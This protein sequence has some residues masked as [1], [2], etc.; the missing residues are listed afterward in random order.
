MRQAFTMIE[1]IFVIVII[2]ILA[3]IAIPKITKS[4]VDAESSFCALEIRQLTGEIYNRFTISGHTIFSEI[5]IYDITNIRLLQNSSDGRTGIVA[6]TNIVTGVEYQCDGSII[7]K[8]IYSYES[9]TNEYKMLL[10]LKDGNS[11]ASTMAFKTLKKNFNLDGAN[12][13]Y[14]IF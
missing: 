1:L 5:P 11:P 13:K 7:A 9:L 3:S 2:G 6:N 4:R 14:Y 10:E 12:T 8:F